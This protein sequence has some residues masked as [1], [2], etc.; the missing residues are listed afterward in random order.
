MGRACE[1]GAGEA[2]PVEA[3]EE[4]VVA[5]LSPSLPVGLM[6][7][8]AET[9]CELADKCIRCIAAVEGASDE[10]HVSLRLTQRLQGF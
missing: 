10:T 7:L 3:V 6:P 9:E 4:C 5:G 8:L 2:E 1:Y